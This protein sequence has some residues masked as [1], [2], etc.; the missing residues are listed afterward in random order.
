MNGSLKETEIENK[1]FS[2]TISMSSNKSSLRSSPVPSCPS[3]FS[4]TTKS[5]EVH[6][7][8]TPV[9]KKATLE[10]TVP[11]IISKKEI[12][13]K[14][15]IGLVPNSRQ[16]SF[17]DVSQHRSF[18]ET[19]ITFDKTLSPKINQNDQSTKPLV[20]KVKTPDS[21]RK[22][23]RIEAVKR[24]NSINQMK[25]DAIKTPPIILKALP[26]ELKVTDGQSFD[27]FFYVK[28]LAIQQIITW[29]FND[30]VLNDNPD[31]ETF[32]DEVN[33]ESI[34]RF[35]EIFPQDSGIYKCVI[36]NE[37]GQVSTSANVIVEGGVL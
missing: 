21:V 1:S 34:L 32:Y 23:R 16:E 24:K 29:Y 8:T 36:Q 6:F 5:S 25:K 3:P 18:S 7:R 27:L 9:F 4:T 17:M 11:E 2:E 13:L 37:H 12:F 26:T 31:M 33:G 19:Q 20:H 10:L 35:F 28:P 30:K 14:R 22:K 15:T